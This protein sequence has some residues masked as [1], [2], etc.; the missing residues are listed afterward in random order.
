MQQHPVPQE[1]TSYEFRLVGD[2]TLKQ[3]LQLA[4]GVGIAFVLYVTP[5]PGIIRWPLVVFS[6]L[7]G[8]ALA[9]L[10]IEERPLSNWIFSFIK[11]VYSPTLYTWQQGASEDIF[12]ENASLT[13]TLLMPQGEEK[14]KEYLSSVPQLQ[15]VSSLEEKEKNFFEKFYELFGSV[16]AATH[17]P[18]TSQVTSTP[19]VYAP[20]I[21]P[22]QPQNQQ[23]IQ[24]ERSVQA[25]TT[26]VIKVERQPVEFKE[27]V[28]RTQVSGVPTS[29]TPVFQQQQAS[30]SS[31]NMAVFAAG[32]S[33]PTPPTQP[34]TVVGQVISVDGR[35][36]EGAILEIREVGGVPKR[37]LR[38]NKLGHFI[39][40]TPLGDGEYEVVTEKDGV[41][42][43]VVKFKASGQVI[44]PILIKARSVV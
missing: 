37:A 6:A 17:F 1:I 22:A 41:E 32:A 19:A 38:T 13:P 25:P 16:Q 2:M 8:V 34:N 12:Q 28:I 18:H 24:Q 33:P 10:P 20:A 31:A 11:A 30:E 3:F 43:D 26:P 42:F 7:F 44:P 36:I 40:V 29:A 35:M 5:I 23:V 9:F 15:D 27:E 21:P 14:A 39:S 4:A